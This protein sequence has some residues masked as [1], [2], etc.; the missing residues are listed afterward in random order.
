MKQRLIIAST[1]LLLAFQFPLLAQPYRS[2]PLNGA[3]WKINYVHKNFPLDLGAF[4]MTSMGDT[5]IGGLQATRVVTSQ[6]AACSGQAI[7]FHVRSRHYFHQDSLG[8]VYELWPNGQMAKRYDLSLPVGDTLQTT[9]FSSSPITYTV[10]S[11]G[12]LQFSDNIP[13]K[14]LYVTAQ[15]M[16][17]TGFFSPVVWVEGIGDIY[18]GPVPVPGIESW[19]EAA[20]YSEDERLLVTNPYAGSACIFDC[21]RLLSA[22]ATAPASITLSPNPAREQLHLLHAD[23]QPLHVRLL[24]LDGRVLGTW[25]LGAATVHTLQLPAATAGLYLLEVRGAD[26]RTQTQRLVLE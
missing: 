19:N 14:A 4:F 8:R 10:D 2:L 3:R 24:A 21:D 16:N 9:D 25:D 6:A 5:V 12:I 17:G 13:R 18:N 22:E 15:M 1:L 7:A 23:A 11:V 26:G 20:C